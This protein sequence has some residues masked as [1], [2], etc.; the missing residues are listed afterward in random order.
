MQKIKVL[1]E[2]DF[3]VDVDKIEVKYYKTILDIIKRS[4]N[5]WQY[6]GAK[7]SISK[8]ETVPWQEAHAGNK[9]YK[10]DMVKNYKAS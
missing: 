2:V 6:S 5:G 7:V 9:I 4:I 10:E 3:F 1:V 8:P